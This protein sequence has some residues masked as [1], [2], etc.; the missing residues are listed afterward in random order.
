MVLGFMVF[1]PLGLAMLAWIIWGNKMVDRVQDAEVHWHSR[2]SGNT[3]FD[4]YRRSELE[5]LEE[6]RRGL[7]R[8]AEEFQHFLRELRSAKDK[9]EFDRF[10]ASRRAGKPAAGSSPDEGAAQPA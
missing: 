2:K 10:M 1:W 4:E 6:E 8:E 3:A 7:D 9:E 5:R